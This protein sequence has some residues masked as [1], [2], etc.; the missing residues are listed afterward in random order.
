MRK[1]EE[2][3]SVLI[4]P[5]DLQQ[6]IINLMINAIQSMTN[7]GVLKI[8]A[9]RNASKILIEVSDSGEGISQ[10]KMSHIFDPFYTT[11]KPGEGTGLGL[12]LTYEIITNYD[13]EISV[14]S[15]EGRG[16]SFTVSFIG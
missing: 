6:I 3:L 5:I 4:D 1:V 7:G 14:E 13:G 15:E 11:K 8:N 9:H 10:A 16:T 2:D 12:W